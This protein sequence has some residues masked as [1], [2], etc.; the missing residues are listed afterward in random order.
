ML[1]HRDSRTTLF[2]QGCFCN[3]R[4]LNPAAPVG[5]APPPPHEGKTSSCTT[6]DRHPHCSEAATGLGEAEEHGDWSQV[7]LGFPR[8]LF[9]AGYV[10][11]QVTA[12][13]ISFFS[14]GVSIPLTTEGCYP[15]GLG[16]QKQGRHFSQRPTAQS[17]HQLHGY[18]ISRV[19]ESQSL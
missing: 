17:G 19:G 9:H 16:E 3:L 18:N 14:Y 5:C 11:E 13:S 4:C 1:V 2:A 15:S 6:S 12:S 7:G 10:T 8:I